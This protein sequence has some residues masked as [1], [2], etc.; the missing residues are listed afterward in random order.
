MQILWPLFFPL[1]GAIIAAI[2]IYARKYTGVAALE[3]VLMW[4]LA[5]GLGLSLMYGGLGHLFVPDQVAESIGWPAGSPFQREVGIWDLAMGIVG[6]LCLKFR[7][8]FW[9]AMIAGAGIFCMGAGLGHVWE[10]VV[11][12]NTAPNNAGTVMYFDLLYPVFLVILLVACRN[13]HSRTG[14]IST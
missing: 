7:G 10:L 5:V 2:H 6:L 9:T 13:M 1:L 8:E 11:N 12:G 3:I 14:K 4:Q